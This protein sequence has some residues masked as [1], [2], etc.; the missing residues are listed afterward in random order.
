MIALEDAIKIFNSHDFDGKTYNVCGWKDLNDRWIFDAIRMPRPG[1][2]PDNLEIGAS[3]PKVWRRNKRYH[4]GVMKENGSLWH[5]ILKGHSC[6]TFPPFMQQAPAPEETFMN[7][8]RVSQATLS[9]LRTALSV[10]L[11][12]TYFFP[13]ENGFK[14]EKWHYTF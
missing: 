3:M 5:Q 13:W 14:R 12:E 2:T 10:F 11:G 9:E 4:L 8:Q 7:Y 6:F 1:D